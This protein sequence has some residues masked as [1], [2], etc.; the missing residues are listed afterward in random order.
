MTAVA[1]RARAVLSTACVIVDRDVIRLVHKQAD[2]H[3]RSW[4]VGRW[5]TGCGRC[6][7]CC[8]PG[9]RG[10]G[11]K[12][13]ESEKNNLLTRGREDG[14]IE[15]CGLLAREGEA[16]GDVRHRHICTVS[17]TTLSLLPCPKPPHMPCWGKVM[18]GV[19]ARAIFGPW[20]SASKAGGCVPPSSPLR[21][22][23]RLSYPLSFLPP[24]FPPSLSLSSQLPLNPARL[25]APLKTAQPRSASPPLARPTRPKREG[26]REISFVGRQPDP[27]HL[28]RGCPN[29]HHLSQFNI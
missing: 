6:R 21:R 10:R 1:T 2:K 14:R 16:L 26:G 29:H 22:C 20:I 8:W 13:E 12:N 27:L 11:D 3:S 23:R 5:R 24:S 19:L 15:Y 4:L 18:S 17:P 25:T 28:L 7:S 9:E